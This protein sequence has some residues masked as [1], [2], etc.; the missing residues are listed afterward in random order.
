VQRL[1]SIFFVL[2]LAACNGYSPQNQL[3]PLKSGIRIKGEHGFQDVLLSSISSVSA[4]VFANAQTGAADR[5][6]LLTG[7][8]IPYA[9]RSIDFGAPQSESLA[10]SSITGQITV[11]FQDDS[12]SQEFRRFNIVDEEHVQDQLH[13]DVTYRA[14]N[15]LDAAWID[16]LP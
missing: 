12:G 10:S 15:K 2:I 7:S 1:A 5:K 6:K 3:E 16:A 8:A 14:R 9:L 4:E 13:P 11:T